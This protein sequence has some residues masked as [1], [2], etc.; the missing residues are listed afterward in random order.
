MSENTHT[1]SISNSG[2]RNQVRKRV[3]EVLLKEKPG[4]GPG[5]L[6]SRH[7]YYVETLRDGKKIFLRR[8]AFLK[9]GFDFVIHVE[10]IDFSKGREAKRRTNP[11]HDD[12]YE[13]LK[14]KKRSNSSNYWKLYKLIED[15]FNCKNVKQVSYQNLEF[16]TGY[17]VDLIIGVYKWFF[18]E[19]DIRDWNYSGRAMCFSGIPKP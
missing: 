15:V 18:I 11:K 7:T 19:Q 10:G 3:L 8:P 16:S 17:P 13:D 4:T 6:A 1:I 12:L 2:T 14:Q 5:D 9:K